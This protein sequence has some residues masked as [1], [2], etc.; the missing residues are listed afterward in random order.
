MADFDFSTLIT[1]RSP[2]DLQTLRNLLATPMADWTA[3]QL[4]QFNQALSKGAYNYTD[5]NRVTACMDYL[6]ERL[7]AAGYVTGYNPIVVHPPEPPKPVS[8]LPDGYTQLEYI[9]STGTQYID[10]RFY[11]NQDTRII[12][13]A[14]ALSMS[15]EYFCIFGTRGSTNSKRYEFLKS[16]QSFYSPYN[17]S[18]GSTMA[19][20]TVR[21]TIDKNKNITS[22]NEATFS[23]QNYSYFECDKSLLIFA[24]NSNGNATLHGSIRVYSCKI[25]DNGTLVINLL[26]CKNNSGVV[27]L[28]D[29]VNNQFFENAGTG[30][31]IAG[32]EI[33]QTSRINNGDRTKIDVSLSPYT[34]YESDAQTQTQMRRYLENVSRL[35][36]VLTLPED[37]A[38]NPTDMNGL[39]IQAANDIEDILLVIQEYLV[40]MQKI[41]LRSGMI[42]AVSGGPGW[43]FGI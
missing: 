13:D 42:W 3:E 8:P 24:C 22:F 39:T 2:E 5:L 32:P 15:P 29:T 11:P 16:G 20:T 38:D 19:G 18:A 6:N 27:G 30:S 41:F 23:T 10:T 17:T 4:A 1:D 28:F 37:T 36:S 7:T 34:W 12:I 14:Q 35:K 31:F 33:I 43:Y 40:A 9:E 25:Y 21:G 26:P